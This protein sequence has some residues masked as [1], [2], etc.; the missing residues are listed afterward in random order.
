MISVGH[1]AGVVDVRVVYF[2]E[3]R[4]DVRERSV[5]VEPRHV[6]ACAE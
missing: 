2:I 5:D 1:R 3:D 6:E 4:R